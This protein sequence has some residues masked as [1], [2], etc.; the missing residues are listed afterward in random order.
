MISYQKNLFIILMSAFL[1]SLGGFLYGYDI[2]VIS[3]ALPFIEKSIYLNP[4]QIGF[5]VGSVLIGSLIGTLASGFLSNLFGR[6]IAI[7]ISAVVFIIGIFLTINS[8]TFLHLVISRLMLGIGV[9]IVATAAPL[10]IAEI[11]PS[12]KRGKYVSL[13]QLF[14]ALGILMAYITDF[15]FSPLANW[16][17]MFEVIL[18]PAAILFISS[19][20]IPK[21]PRWLIMRSKNKVALNLLSK[22][23]SDK[24]AKLI[25]TEIENEV[26]NDKISKMALVSKKLI[27]P[28]FIALS[29]AICN[30]LTGINVFLQYIP[31]I[32]HEINFFSI[33]SSIFV[34]IIIGLV[35]FIC[36][37]VAI[38]L[39]DRIGRKK[40][41]SYGVLGI[42]ISL[43]GLAFNALFLRPSQLSAE[44]SIFELFVFIISYATGPGVIVW[45]AISELFPTQIRSYEMS[46]CIF[47]N[48]LSGATLATF[49]PWI[50][51]SYGIGYSYLLCCLFSILYFLVVT[52]LLPETC[53][54]SLEYIQENFKNLIFKKSKA[55]NE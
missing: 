20:F 32:L 45:L 19:F 15:I 50:D 53:G 2:G 49:F 51:K 17:A 46:I 4:V 18:V 23:Y 36:T 44:L 24:Q 11:V 9:G 12:D 33:Q 38:M 42:V 5:V 55:I 41:M 37:I 34:S 7:R 16:H 48:S 10:Y 6:R 21:S 43:A 39:V 30:Q 25:C 31:S 26:K 27:L 54:Q 28:F 8:A 52:L 35:N 13:F 47:F 40:L 14:L 1:A 3:G 29:I 22:L